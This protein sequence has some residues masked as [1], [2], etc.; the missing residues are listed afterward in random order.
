MNWKNVLYL[1]RVD[2]KSGRLIRGVKTTRYRES[3]ILAYWP[4]WVAAIIGVLGGLLANF[5][6]SAIYS[7]AGVIPGL[8]SLSEAALSFFVSLPTL[9]LILSV[10]MTMLQ[11]IQL[12]GVKATGQVMY[13]LPVTWQEHTLASI[14][15]NLF[16]I[17]LATVIGFAAGVIAF[18]VFNGLIVSA[19]LTSL[20]LFAAAF[21]ASATTEILR[22]LQVRFTG[23][24]YKSS[25]KAAVWV[26]FIGTLAFFLIFYIIYLSL[27]QGSVAFIQG[28]AQ[29]QNTVWFIPFVWIGVTL[30]YLLNGVILQGIV[31]VALSAIFLAGMYYL[32]IELNKRFGL[33]EPPAITVQKSGTIYAP[34]TG[35]LGKLGFSSVEAALINKDIRAFTRRR[36]LI[37]IFIVPIVFI[38]LPLMQSVGITSNPNTPS[39]VGVFFVGMTFLLPASVMAMSMGNMLIGEEGQAVWRIYASPISPKNL[40]KSKLFFLMALSL[41][42]LLVTGIV[43][44]VFYHP[45]IRV[46]ITGLIEG[47]LLVIGLGS[48]ALSIGFKG[49]DFTVSRRTRMIRQRWALISLGVCGVAGLAILAPILPYV[50]SEF[51]SSI[52]ATGPVSD[53]NLAISL[54]ISAVIATVIAAIF[55]RV[56]INSAADLIRKAET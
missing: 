46:I 50:I 2:R 31:F 25:G 43:G 52:L 37:S 49:A 9:I 34:K 38:I 27:T 39:E 6:V 28:L 24:V 41:L 11:Q 18:S 42:V 29:A 8:P 56:N 47:F 23:A 1:L 26:R 13:W 15:A 21:M 20:A 55:Y 33:Y 32:A 17:P 22:V 44:T 35:F 48:I 3:G 51:L 54:G 16:G 4:Y 40:V 12:A 36:E 7:G 10:V 14:L 45:S 53:L 19:V 5:A 30:F